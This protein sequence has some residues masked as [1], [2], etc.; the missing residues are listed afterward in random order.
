MKVKFL[1][2]FICSIFLLSA[3]NQTEIVEDEM[4]ITEEPA[5]ILEMDFLGSWTR[6]A[7]YI[8]GVL[9]H[10]TPADLT[11]NADQTYS[12]ATDVCATSGTYEGVGD[13]TV[14]MIM[15]QSNCP[16]NIP[17]PFTVTY[18]YTIEEN[19]DGDEVM[20]MNTANVTETYVR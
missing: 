14:V 9:E 5:E 20:T 17:L 8:D 10:T 7:T 13:N 4:P 6:T 15:S 19:E 18:T 3:C 16:G 12:S 1:F 11:F 2:L